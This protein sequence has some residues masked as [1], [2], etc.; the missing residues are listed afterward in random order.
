[1]MQKK[2]F[3]HGDL[4]EEIYMEMPPGYNASGNTNLVFK[5]KKDIV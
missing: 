2:S 1:M 4:S 3:L 5:L